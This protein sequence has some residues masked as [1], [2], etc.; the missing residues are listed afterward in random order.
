MRRL[1]MRCLRGRRLIVGRFRTQSFA[2]VAPPSP[3]AGFFLPRCNCFLRG[4][5]I[6]RKHGRDEGLDYLA[7][8]YIDCDLHKRPNL[9]GIDPISGEITV[10]FNPRGDRWDDRFR[11]EGVFLRG[12]TAMGRTTIEVPQI[13]SDDQMGLRWST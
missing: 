12:S 5:V 9:P 8:A 2:Q 3:T 7:L 1:P 4:H 6:P 10:L 13:N 11:W